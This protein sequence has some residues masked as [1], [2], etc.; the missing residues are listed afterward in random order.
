[1]QPVRALAHALNGAVWRASARTSARLCQKHSISRLRHVAH[2]D[3]THNEVARS[4]LAGLLLRHEKIRVMRESIT[5]MRLLRVYE[6][7]NSGL[8]QL[9]ANSVSFFMNSFVFATVGFVSC[10]R[11]NLAFRP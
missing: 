1:M 5:F 8:R 4:S 2:V 9:G 11:K 10:V 3:D 7:T 6:K